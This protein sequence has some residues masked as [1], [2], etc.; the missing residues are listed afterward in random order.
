[1]IEIFAK[2][3]SLRIRPKKLHTIKLQNVIYRSIHCQCFADNYSLTSSLQLMIYDCTWSEI[4]S[5]PF[6]VT[7]V[8]LKK[9]SNETKYI[10]CTS[11]SICDNVGRKIFSRAKSFR[12]DL[13]TEKKS[14]YEQSRIDSDCKIANAHQRQ[15]Q[16]KYTS[17]VYMHAMNLLCVYI[18]RHSPSTRD[19]AA[20]AAVSHTYTYIACI[21][22]CD[23]W[24][25]SRKRFQRTTRNLKQH[26]KAP[27]RS[28]F[29]L[30]RLFFPDAIS[31]VR[32]INRFPRLGKTRGL[33]FR[34]LY[35][36]LLIFIFWQARG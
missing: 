1:M 19:N 15:V 28:F 18:K 13:A 2:H 24:L 16:Q 26:L 32:F 8:I 5:Q 7:F 21:F 3:F 33:F 14:A 23:V 12:E 29:P 6:L 17:G 35:S 25:P 36:R 31:H 34:R 9:A 11:I 22:S 27:L 20:D 30:S 10:A 4:H